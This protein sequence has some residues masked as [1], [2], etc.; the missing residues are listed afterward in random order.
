V[1]KIRNILLLLAFSSGVPAC[2][3][4]AVDLDATAIA[5][6]SEPGVLAVAHER[7]EKLLVDDERLYWTGSR[8]L[9]SDRSNVW[10]LRSCRKETCA[11]SLVTYAAQPSHYGN[12]FWV[13]GGQIYWYDWRGLVSCAIAGCDGAPRSIA[14][15]FDGAD[16][17]FDDDY[18][19]SS[20]FDALYRSSLSEPGPRQLLGSSPTAIRRIAV[21]GA[22]VYLVTENG[23]LAEGTGKPQLLRVHEDG[24]AAVETIAT[25]V[26]V[27]L[28]YDF[29]IAADETSIYWTDNLI[30]GWI[31]RCPL[32][33]CSR[34]WDATGP[35]R[36][37]Q[38][39]LIDDAR[40]YYQ[41]E[42]AP[43]EYVLASCSLPTCLASTTVQKR[44]DAPKAFAVDD[45]YVYW[46][47][48]ER[49]FMRGLKSGSS[50]PEVLTR[51][52]S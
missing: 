33:D 4:T 32:A 9:R 36:A 12:N 20:D 42:A 16:P 13:S 24:A 46:Y 14:P 3:A 18:V 25:E 50:P 52:A 1:V 28:H 51:C 38:T 47:Q 26:N 10:F 6:S 40:L 30:F 41:Y 45:R 37:P 35:F 31:N 23:A 5:T 8:L 7:I 17:A 27:S 43:Y 11:S 15:V 29:G 48:D 44:L 34:P 49:T 2:S 22:Y 39:L 21:V 19:Y